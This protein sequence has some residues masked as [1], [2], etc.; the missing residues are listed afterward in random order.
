MLR[1]KVDEIDKVLQNQPDYPYLEQE[2][3]AAQQ[4]IISDRNSAREVTRC[5]QEELDKTRQF[6]EEY[7][8]NRLSVAKQFA[9]LGVQLKK[10][11]EEL[12][13]Q[14][15]Q[16]PSSEPTFP[17]HE[18]DILTTNITKVGSKASQIDPLQM[19][20]KLLKE[21]VQRLEKARAHHS[22]DDSGAGTQRYQTTN[23]AEMIDQT[24]NLN[25]TPGAPLQVE[26]TSVEPHVDELTPAIG[27]PTVKIPGP[28]YPPLN[29]NPLNRGPKVLDSTSRVRGTT[30]LA[31]ESSEVFRK[32]EKRKRNPLV[33]EFAN[34]DVP[35]G[36]RSKK[37]RA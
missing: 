14:R 27:V 32:V 1:R 6:T 36:P 15:S 35:S 19:E 26:P 22:P 20:L 18:I 23:R 12:A 17:A 3:S 30:K 21:R 28:L 16:K 33:E 4:T 29:Q 7:N 2:L 9:S 31:P 11:K 8:L 37:R 34:L 5:L 10:L 24:L 25:E 13:E